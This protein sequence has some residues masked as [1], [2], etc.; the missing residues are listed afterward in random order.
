VRGTRFGGGGEVMD[1]AVYVDQVASQR[2]S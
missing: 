2:Q 1:V